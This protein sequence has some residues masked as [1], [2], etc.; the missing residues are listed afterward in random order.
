VA[1]QQIEQY[2]RNLP[3]A[4]EDAEAL[5]VDSRAVLKSMESQH[6]LLTERA[7]GIYS[8]SHL[9]FQEY[10]TA[11][12]ILDL[13]NPAAQEVAL[14]K[15]IE[16]VGEQR[17][18][19]VFLLVVEGLDN[20]DY[21]LW[22]MKQR[23]DSIV[24]DD[25][26]LQQFL[27]WVQVKSASV[28]STNKPAVIRAFY[29][30]LTLTL[31]HTFTVELFCHA[32]AFDFAL[33][34]ALDLALDFDLDIVVDLNHG[35]DRFLEH[36]LIFAEDPESKSQMQEIRY[37]L[38]DSKNRDRFQQ[39]WEQNGSQWTEDLH[40]IMIKYRNIGH[41]WRFTDQQKAKLQEYDDANLLLADCLNSECYVSREVRE[42][43]EATMLLPVAEIEK[44]KEERRMKTE[45][46]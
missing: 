40:Q 32:L 25:Q 1:T 7:T 29:Q 23:I 37:R 43:I 45:E 3:G 39:W 35:L 16:H 13:S 22:L 41:D 18:K 34:N 17:W 14:Q 36:G 28:E 42:E 33:I 38:P 20:A 27:E 26:K 8:F 10:F 24:E 46:H 44:W 4:S 19:E 12:N 21:L 5:L 6:G 15:L 9:T 31:D 30:A 2:I 11:K